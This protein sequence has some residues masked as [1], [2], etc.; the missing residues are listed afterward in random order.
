MYLA[1]PI[2]RGFVLNSTNFHG[3]SYSQ[4]VYGIYRHDMP[5]SMTGIVK[6]VDD[7]KTAYHAW[8][9][10]GATEYPRERIIDDYNNPRKANDVKK[11]PV[12]KVSTKVSTLKMTPIQN[13]V[14]TKN[15]N[16]DSDNSDDACNNDSNNERYDREIVPSITLQSSNG[17]DLMFE[18][19]AVLNWRDK[20]EQI[21]TVN[22][23]NKINDMHLRSLFNEMKTKAN[24]L[25][26][27]ISSETSLTFDNDE[28]KY[29]FLFHII[30][31]GR[32]FYH[33]VI[34][35][36]TFC[37]YLMD[38]YQNLYTFMKQKLRL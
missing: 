23:L 4:E 31:K 36:P 27:V 12:K 21:M 17:E 34:L 8:L 18:R 2:V 14:E 25:Y 37:L 19:L 20:D 9:E 7:P 22:A 24:S 33:N 30:A 28:E 32:D 13:Y 5:S 1:P 3:L 38:Q 11:S 16:I 26:E 6:N 15:D 35:D 29:N 10:N